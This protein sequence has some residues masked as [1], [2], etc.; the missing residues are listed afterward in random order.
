MKPLIL[1]LVV[2]GIAALVIR[3]TAT[4]A[5]MALAARIAMA[6]MLLF[7]AIGHF[8]FTKG[9]TM[10]LPASVPFK[11]GVIYLTGIL[12]IAGAAGLL[13]P[14]V[15]TG[16]AC[17]LI[18]FFILLLPANIYAAILH[19]DYEKGTYAGKG[20]SYLWFRIPLQVFFIV[21]VYIS[22]VLH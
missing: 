10:M 11:A 7:T 20:L 15:R 2:F 12:E 1:L 16:A 14:S 18:V 17:A 22:A 5:D 6:A 13:V 8:M 19:I 21:W 3:L 4:Q 9:M